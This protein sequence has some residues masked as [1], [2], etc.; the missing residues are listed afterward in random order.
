MSVDASCD[1]LWIGIGFANSGFRCYEY[2]EDSGFI[3]YCAPQRFLDQTEQPVTALTLSFPYVFASLGLGST[4]LLLKRLKPKESIKDA[5]WEQLSWLKSN[6]QHACLPALSLRRLGNEIAAS[7]AYSAEDVRGNRCL[8]VQ[9]LRVSYSPMAHPETFPSPGLGIDSNA[10]RFVDSPRWH[11]RTFEAGTSVF[12]THPAADSCPNALS[13]SHP[14]LL[15]ALPDNTIMIYLVTSSTRGLSLSN[16]SRLW[17]HTSGISGAEVNGRGK[18]VTI[19]SKGG[20]I[21]VW[22][23]EGLASGQAQGRTSTALVPIKDAVPGGLSGSV[24]GQATDT[25]SRLDHDELTKSWIAFDDEQVLVLG[26]RRDERV[27]S[28]YD[29][30]K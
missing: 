27:L 6:R 26:E 21:R 10:D 23:L 16:G 24:G 25:H 17:G 2:S 30:T 5:V 8:R 19:S 20:E 18:A 4:N 14:Y 11:T 3:E 13:Y 15:V 9:E 12:P 29:F 7:I 22:D 1:G 28:R